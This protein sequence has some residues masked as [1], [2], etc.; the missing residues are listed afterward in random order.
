MFV[1]GVA[2]GEAVF[3]GPAYFCIARY[4]AISARIRFASALKNFASEAC[5]GVNSLRSVGIAVDFGSG[6]GVDGGSG[7]TLEL[8]PGKHGPC[9]GI[10]RFD[11]A[12]R[13]EGV[14]YRDPSIALDLSFPTP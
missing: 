2:D 13:R 11:K 9:K 10:D 7:C 14:S 12:P 5:C 3:L 6:V 8:L 1:A 4:S